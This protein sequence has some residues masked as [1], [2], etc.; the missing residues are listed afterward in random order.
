[1]R[2]F[3]T[4]I[5]HFKN[6]E[7]YCMEEILL[8]PFIWRRKLLA[9]HI[10]VGTQPTAHIIRVCKYFWHAPFNVMDIF[11]VCVWGEGQVGSVKEKSL[12]GAKSLLALEKETI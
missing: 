1:M 12:K 7:Q 3:I 5:L 10:L 4:P 9:G 8:E 2:L 6:E 11:L